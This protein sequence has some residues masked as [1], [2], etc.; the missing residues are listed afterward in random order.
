[1]PESKQQLAYIGRG[2]YEDGKAYRCG[3]IVVTLTGEPREFRC[4]SPIRPNPLQ[5]IAY[6][7]RLAPHMYIEVMGKPLINAIQE[8]VDVYLVDDPVLLKLR[9][10][11]EK[12]VVYARRQG[13]QS[14]GNGSTGQ[15]ATALISSPSGSFD[16]VVIE[17][18]EENK[19]DVRE[20]SVLL[21]TASRNLDILEPFSR[22]TLAMR[23]VHEARELDAK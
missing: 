14:R 20:A 1:M 2:E 8:L 12:P 6:G 13:S 16:P 18:F 3:V 7:V 11:V 17:S 15:D 9:Q 4:T 5:R 21:E 19:D 22:L 23:A 10:S